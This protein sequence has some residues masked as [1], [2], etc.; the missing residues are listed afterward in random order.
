MNSNQRPSLAGTLI[1]ER[2]REGGGERG[3]GERGGESGGE[4]GR[5]RGGEWGERGGG[6]EVLQVILMINKTHSFLTGVTSLSETSPSLS[7]SFCGVHSLEED[8]TCMA[9]S[10]SFSGDMGGASLFN[11]IVLVESIENTSLFCLMN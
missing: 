9:S 2:G 3:G 5:G 11:V 1:D 7:S 8:E 10:E 4:R 6:R